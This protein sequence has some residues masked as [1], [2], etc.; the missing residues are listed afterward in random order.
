VPIDP[1]TNVPYRYA[2]IGNGS[3]CSGYHL[4][5]VIESNSFEPLATDFDA[6][7]AGAVCTGS[8]ADFSGLSAVCDASAG[9]A[10]PGGSER[11]Y[12]VIP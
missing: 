4:G 12:D 9:S 7:V 10:A 11:C 3:I 2:A 6:A 1:R 5:A 8:A